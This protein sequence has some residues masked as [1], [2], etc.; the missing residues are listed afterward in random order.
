MV[1]LNPIIVYMATARLAEEETCV[2][3]ARVTSIGDYWSCAASAQLSLYKPD[4]DTNL[5]GT[6]PNFM[7]HFDC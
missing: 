5:D 2:K 6:G 3:E 7:K 4:S 1:G